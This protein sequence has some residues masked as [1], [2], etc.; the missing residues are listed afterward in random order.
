MKRVVI[1]AS[2]FVTKTDMFNCLREALGAE[3]FYGSNLDALHDKLTMVFEPTE[4]TVKSFPEAI[5][6]LGAYANIFWH[7]LDDCTEENKNLTVRFE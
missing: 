6:H 3:N 7:V 2:E 1:D 4:I 5:R